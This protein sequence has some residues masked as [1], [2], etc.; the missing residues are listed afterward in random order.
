MIA[1]QRAINLRTQSVSIIIM[2]TASMPTRLIVAFGN[3]VYDYIE[4]P[5]LRTRGRVLSGC[6]TNACVV[7]SQ[8]GI[9]TTLVGRV[10]VDLYDRFRADILRHEINADVQLCAQTGGFRLVY[11]DYGNRTLDVLGIADSIEDV[12][13][14][15]KKSAAIIV[16]PILGEVSLDLIQKIRATCDAPIF[17]DPQGLLR[18]IGSGGRIEHFLPDNFEKIAPLCHVIKANE[19]EA[20]VLTGIDPRKDAVT[21]V[22][23]LKSLGCAIA[24]VTIAEMGSIIDNGSEIFVIPA[25]NTQAIDPT[26]AGDTYMAGFIYAYLLN[27]DDLYAAG[28]YGSAVASIWIEHTGPDVQVFGD[29]IIRRTTTL[30]N[31][32]RRETL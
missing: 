31:L 16:G 2:E 3:P 28:C 24:I 8:L 20:F 13:E 9:Q 25:Y 26:G 19:L 22:R 21:A 12:P 18:R 4:T 1:C 14:S 29:E 7:L 5:S 10:G 27:P 32:K 15:C 23:R 11:D 17:L 6:S 30:L